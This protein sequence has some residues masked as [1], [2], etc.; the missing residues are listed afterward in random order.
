[1]SWNDEVRPPPRPGESQKR[2]VSA[3]GAACQADLARRKVL[4]VGAGSVGLD[5]V[6]RLAASGLCELTVMDFDVVE[7]QNLDRLIG[8]SGRDALLRRPK[9][10][11]AKRE[12]T[13]AAT[14]ADFGIASS[15]WSICEPE[16][17]RLAL[18]YDLIFSCVDRNWPRA[19]LNALAYTDLIPVIDGGIAID[20]FESGE[21][22]N[23]TWRSHVARPG[24]PCMGCNGQLTSGRCRLK[25][26]DCSRTPSTSRD[27]GRGSWAMPTWRH[28]R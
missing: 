15:N 25:S 22:R 14:A 21:M 18:D 10:H 1:M 12:A 20:V 24:R 3:W 4:V 19:V 5:V 7:A 28:S 6:V 17:L 13:T 26:R 27:P 2:T 9:I 8:A 16:G 23:A 11:V